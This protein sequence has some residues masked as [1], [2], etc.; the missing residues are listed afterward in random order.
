MLSVIV[1]G[2]DI[3][4]LVGADLSGLLQHDLTVAL[5]KSG[6]D[7]QR[8]TLAYN[9]P[10]VGHEPHV[11]IQDDVNVI[12]D[13]QRLVLVD[14]RVLAQRR[15]GSEQARCREPRY[16]HP[17][18]WCCSFVHSRLPLVVYRPIHMT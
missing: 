1:S 12:G 6:V 13:L 5:T 2:R 4:L 15:P 16:V 14:Q 8:C 7:N 11:V 3:Q 17:R 18:P 9:D 10:D